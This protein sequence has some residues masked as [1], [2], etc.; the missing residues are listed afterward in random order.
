MSTPT[1]IDFWTWV[2]DIQNEV[3]LFEAEYP[4]ITVNV[5]NVGQGGEHY[6]KVRTALEAGDGGP[7]VM[8]M[9]YQYVSSFVLTNSLLN[10]KEYGADGVQD[11]FVPWVWSQVSD[12]AHV[13]AIPQDSG[14]VGTLYREDIFAEAG[15]D[16]SPETWAEFAS[17]AQQVKEET[18]SYITNFASNEPGAFLSLL[19]QAG[20][21]PFSFDGSETLGISLNNDRS[22]EVVAYW[23][24][25]VQNDLVGVD[26][27]FT[28]TWY[29][30]L[31]NGTYASWQT[32]AWG[33][34]FLQGTA[35]D[36][37]G[38]WRAAPLPQWDA[39]APSAGN[40]GGSSTA[41]LA[42]TDAPIAASEFAKWL[43][44]NAES[45]EMFANEQFLFPTRTEILESPEFTSDELEFYGGQRVNEVFAEISATVDSDFQWLPIADYVFGSFNE[46]IGAAIAERGDLLAGLDEWQADVVEY[47]TAQGFTVV[48]S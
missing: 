27:D 36:T 28:D 14:P 3:D 15:L 23:Q 19:W 22:K 9:E 18:G 7:D 48:E 8:Q 42:N 46:T 37:S 44:T 12:D 5:Q 25:L 47:A 31:A 43:N 10:L 30:G 45:T 26:P 17:A 11:Q 39:S 32:A 2:P 24:D 16:G 13:W 38:L 21:S 6:T 35:A 40:W 4:D 33:P 41:V 20:A 34:L 1:T 29:Q